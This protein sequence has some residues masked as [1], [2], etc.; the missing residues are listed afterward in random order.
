MKFIELTSQ[1]G[2]VYINAKRICTVGLASNHVNTLIISTG[3]VM[4][5]VTEKPAAVLALINKDV[6]S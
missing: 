2:K 3:G 5:F 4:T 6:E 1:H